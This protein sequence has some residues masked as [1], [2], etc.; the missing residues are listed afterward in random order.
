MPECQWG[1]HP[2]QLGLPVFPPPGH[3]ALTNTQLSA[4]LAMGK[5][6]VAQCSDPTVREPLRRY[7]NFGEAGHRER[8]REL[9]SDGAHACKPRVQLCMF[10]GAT[11]LPKGEHKIMSGAAAQSNVVTQECIFLHRVAPAPKHATVVFSPC[12]FLWRCQCY[13]Q[14]P[15]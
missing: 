4:N 13:S 6:L 12:F 8:E 10:L 9:K 7:A 14:P 5:P 11:P 1:Q 15:S 2:C 3:C